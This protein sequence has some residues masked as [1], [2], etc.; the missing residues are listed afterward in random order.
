MKNRNKN[1]CAALI[2]AGVFSIV[3]L[4]I[5]YVLPWC[6]EA[7]YAGEVIRH[8]YR[9]G[10]DATPLFYTESERTWEIMQKMDKES[11]VSDKVEGA[12]KA[13]AGQGS[14]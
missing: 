14:G 2:C 3:C 10:R 6:S 8:S 5:A 1:I 11:N 12:E 13:R 4:L 9:H 7:G